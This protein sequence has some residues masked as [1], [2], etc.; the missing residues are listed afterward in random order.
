MTV[1][2][3]CS[4][5]PLKKEISAFAVFTMQML[6]EEVVAKVDEEEFLLSAC[7]VT[8]TMFNV[9]CDI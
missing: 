5:T 9:Y 7:N 4:S 3:M 1:W 6:F 8:G 2:M